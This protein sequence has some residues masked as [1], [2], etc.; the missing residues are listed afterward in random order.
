MGFRLLVFEGDNM[1]RPRIAIMDE[2]VRR[3]PVTFDFTMALHVQVIKSNVV[4]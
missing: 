2:V 3:Y 4:P 1:P